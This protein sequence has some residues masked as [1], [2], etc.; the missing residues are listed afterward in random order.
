M[1]RAIHRFIDGEIKLKYF[2]YS[3]FRALKQSSGI[4]F[5]FYLKSV[6]VY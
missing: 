1:G 3:E 2:G 4:S 5:L 6:T